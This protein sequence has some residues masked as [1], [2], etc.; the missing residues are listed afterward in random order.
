MAF[1]LACENGNTVLAKHLYN[2]NPTIDI[3]AENHY[4]FL[5]AC[6]HHR[7]EVA[8]WLESLNIEYYVEIISNGLIIKYRTNNEFTLAVKMLEEDYDG[9]YDKVMK[10]LK[11]LEPKEPNNDDFTCIICREEN[12]KIIKTP[13]NHI[14]CIICLL[15]WFLTINAKSNF[16][17]GYCRS[18]FNWCTCTHIKKV[19][20]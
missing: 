3:R 20:N 7:L 15:S 8:K 13:C 16:K 18:I 6:K 12:D 2:L 1:R 19:E 10:M 14:Y 5:K 4:A 9:N 17:C 11:I